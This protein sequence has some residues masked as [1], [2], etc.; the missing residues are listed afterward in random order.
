MGHQW[1]LITCLLQLYSKIF[2]L[3]I[4][5]QRKEK[6][7]RTIFFL[8]LNE[9]AHKCLYWSHYPNFLINWMKTLPFKNVVSLTL[10]FCPTPL[11]RRTY[12]DVTLDRLYGGSRRGNT[13]VVRHNQIPVSLQTHNLSLLY[14]WKN[15]IM[16]LFVFWAHFIRHG[17]Q[18]NSKYLR[19]HQS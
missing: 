12:S 16:Y 2:L 7:V 14:A 1:N 8:S 10:D 11:P 19:D 4:S 13:V 9:I 3:R 5:F 15:I 6:H 17:H 18:A